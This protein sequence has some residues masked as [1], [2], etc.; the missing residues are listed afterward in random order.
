MLCVIGDLVEDIVVW[1]PESLNYGADT[2]SRIVRTRGGSASNV[3]VFAATVARNETNQAPSSRLIAQVG[4]DRLGDQLIGALRDA[5]VDPCVVRGG[6]TGSIVVIVSPDGERTM[7]TDRAASTQLQQAPEKWFESVS[8]L[9]VPAY[10]LFSE[11]LAT[12]A[13]SCIATA[14]DK[15]IPVSIDA[16]SASL[17]KEFGVNKFRELIHQLRPKIF[18]CNTDEAEILNLTT[19]PLDLDIVVI[20]AGARPT[21]LIENNVVKT[22]EVEPVGEIIDTTGAGDAF[23]AGFLTKFGENNL[24][25]YICVLAGHQLAAR[26]L[27]SPGAT[28]DAQ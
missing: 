23:A 27:R 2:P 20:K 10:S 8:L 16:S 24:D 22:I 12:A 19:Q 14:H 15:N 13:R 18:F 21:T 7:L 28:M 9:H 26:V 17:I 4:D 11:P 6:R 3:A 5:G 1:L 25:T